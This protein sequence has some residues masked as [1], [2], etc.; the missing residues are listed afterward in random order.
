[1]QRSKAVYSIAR[2]VIYKLNL[3]LKPLN[4]GVIRI[5]FFDVSYY[6]DF[7]I[8]VEIRFSTETE[9]RNAYWTL[10]LYFIKKRIRSALLNAGIDKRHVTSTVFRVYS[11]EHI[12]KNGGD[13][14]FYR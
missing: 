3:G 14:Y 7:D 4:D 11:Q 1:M 8:G 12:D 10:R 5:D 2:L 13:F 6:E 9:V